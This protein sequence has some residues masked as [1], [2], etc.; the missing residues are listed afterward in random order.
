MN[1]VTYGRLDKVLRVLG[2]SCRITTLRTKARVYEHSE[3]GAMI[4]L[5]VVAEGNKVLPH[6]LAAVRGTLDLYGVADPL[7]FAAELQKAS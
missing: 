4:V 2:F 6:H 5:P 3:T 1:E 7:N